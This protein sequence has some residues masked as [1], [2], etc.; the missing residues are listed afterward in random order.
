[1]VVQPWP[2][3]SAGRW[4]ISAEGGSAPRWRRD[5]RELF[6]IDA[7]GRLTAVA[8]STQ[9]TFAIQQSTVLMQTPLPLGQ[10]GAE[11]AYDAAPDGQRFLLLVPQGPASSIPLTVRLNWAR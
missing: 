3:P 4:Q 11:S 6:F 7:R 8:V 5:G 10:S 9:G 2:D 1:V